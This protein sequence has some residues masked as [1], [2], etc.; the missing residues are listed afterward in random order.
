MNPKTILDEVYKMIE[1]ANYKMF[2]IWTTHI[3]L[4]WRWWLGV[5]LTILPW[6]VWIKIRDK[7]DTPRLFTVGLGV[8]VITNIMDNVGLSYNLWHYD[9]NVSPASNIFIPWD[10]A[11]IPVGIMLILQF[12]PEINVYIKAVAFAFFTAFIFQ[13]FLSWIG[14]YDMVNWKYWYSFIIC[15]LLYLFFNYIYNSKLLNV[16]SNT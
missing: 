9:I 12:K 10:Y 2:N 7:K 15:I 11:L 5:V 16:H 1:T 13:P 4:S 3:F 14:M 6:I 8:M